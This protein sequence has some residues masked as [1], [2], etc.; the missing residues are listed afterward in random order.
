MTARRLAL[1]AWLPVWLLVLVPSTA[2]AQEFS[3]GG[4]AQLGY[5]VLNADDAS[6]DEGID[7][8]LGFGLGGQ[9]IVGMSENVGFQ[10]EAGW[11]RRGAATSLRLFEINGATT[12]V[13][14][15]LMLDYLEVPLLL[16]L[17]YQ[18]DESSFTPKL[19][20]GP[21]LAAF[22]TGKV[23][24]TGFGISIESDLEPGEDIDPFD[25]GIVL[26]FGGDFDLGNG[27]ILTGDI[28]AQHGIVGV[29]VNDGDSS[30]YNLAV[31]VNVGIAF[32]I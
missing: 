28:R 29:E 17:H 5:V 2:Q 4:R 26:G 23:R 8:R 9:A 16:R 12:G 3:L 31:L 7:G 10:I 13:E 20:I 21:Y 24:A 19:L 15:E 1:I 18:S 25:L 22:V 30:L 27:A 11:A 32:G 14:Q 6:A